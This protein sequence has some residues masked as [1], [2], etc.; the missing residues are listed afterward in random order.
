[1]AQRLRICTVLAIAACLLSSCG[2]EPIQS[3]DDSAPVGTAK[4]ADRIPSE[5]STAGE[6][7]AETTTDAPAESTDAADT[8][9]SQTQGDGSLQNGVWWGVGSNDDWYFEFTDGNKG[10]VIYQSMG[11]AL[12]FEYERSGNLV[13]F[14]MGTRDNIKKATVS[15]ERDD[16]FTLSFEGG[17]V[18]VLTKQEE[19]SLSD[20]HFYSTAKLIEMARARETAANSKTYDRTETDIDEDGNIVIRMYQDGKGDEPYTV[21][22]DRFT[23]KAKDSLGYSFDLSGYGDATN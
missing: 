14:Y 6:S 18:Q 7:G 21:S 11:A 5:S 22:I 13:T 20:F 19:T 4:I 3:G 12:N 23:A 10:T 8:T 16:R 1:M 9:A 2:M 15:D 17:D